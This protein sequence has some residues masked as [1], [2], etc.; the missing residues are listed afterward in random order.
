MATRRVAAAVAIVPPRGW[1]ASLPPLGDS[2]PFTH[3]AP[4]LS[5]PIQSPSSV[6]KASPT[7]GTPT[8]GFGPAYRQVTLQHLDGSAV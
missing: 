3:A 6:T 7:A 2:D 8:A 1:P 5:S 4:A